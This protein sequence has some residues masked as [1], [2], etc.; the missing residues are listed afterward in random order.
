MTS[1]VLCWCLFCLILDRGVTHVV[2]LESGL[3]RGAG[4]T[5]VALLSLLT[6]GSDE[7]DETGVAL[8]SGEKKTPQTPVTLTHLDLGA[9]ALNVNLNH[10]FIII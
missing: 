3:S 10:Y 8:W 1:Q 2:S 4:Q 9:L 6:R 7:A 5:P